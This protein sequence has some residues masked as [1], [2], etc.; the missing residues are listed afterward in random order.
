MIMP[1]LVNLSMAEAIDQLKNMGITSVHYTMVV[2][3]DYAV[4]TVISTQPVADS[5][6]FKNSDIMIVV[7]GRLYTP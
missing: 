2:N 1:N 7:Q 5:E 4:S 6:I 3:S